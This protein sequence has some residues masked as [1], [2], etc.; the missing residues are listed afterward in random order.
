MYSKHMLIRYETSLRLA[1]K[2]RIHIDQLAEIGDAVWR[3]SVRR[4]VESRLEELYAC[5][6]H[7]HSS[8]D[9]QRRIVCANCQRASLHKRSSK[10]TDKVAIL[11]PVDTSLVHR[12]L[13]HFRIRFGD[14]R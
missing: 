6:A 7:L 12:L 11:D 1:H 5:P 4:L 8:G 10:R 2:L 14:E 9:V 3:R 13:V